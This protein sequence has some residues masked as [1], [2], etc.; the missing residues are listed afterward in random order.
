MTGQKNLTSLACVGEVMLEFS[1][2]A[3]ESYQLGV[4]GDSFNTAVYLKRLWPDGDVAYVT[5]VG[6]DQPSNRVL[7]A[8]ESHNL[9]TQLVERRKA[10]S[11]GLYVVTL[12]EDG[13]RSFSYWRSAS[14]ARTLFTP[15]WQAALD[16]L[17]KFDLVYLSGISI[18]ILPMEV[19]HRLL[20]WIDDFRVA[21][22]L[23]AFDSNYRPA[24]WE[25]VDTARECT[26]AMWRRCDVALP[27]VDDEQMLFADA[28][29]AAVMQR[30]REAGVSHGA[31]KRGAEGPIGFDGSTLSPAQ[32]TPVKVVDSTAAGD[33]FN[34][35]F[36]AAYA[37]GQSLVD[38]MAS[39]HNLAAKVVQYRGAITPN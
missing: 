3:D 39:G 16:E 13:E 21:G 24:L 15:P 23:F 34:A 27:S 25:S 7:T 26:M 9:N 18:A 30:L 20:E 22:G 4:A 32:Q 12:A 1:P 14:A 29:E 28:N 35:G 31:L 36:L 5:A 6:Q 33:S 17:S 11:V 2:L 8:L 37:Q 38:C 10:S 19:R